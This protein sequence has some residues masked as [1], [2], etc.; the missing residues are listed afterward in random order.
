M[1]RVGG[2]PLSEFSIHRKPT[3]TDHTIY[4]TSNHLTQH[5]L[6]AYR[7]MIHRLH[8]IP[9]TTEKFHNEL[10]TIHGIVQNNG[11]TRKTIDK[12]ITQHKNKT[13]TYKNTGNTNK[14]WIT[15][16]YI[17]KETYRLKNFFTKHNISIQN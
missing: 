14:T 9:M 15:L 17:G 7:S 3:T 6:A 2:L 1:I 4:L 13:N 12:P 16:T 11:F 5:K 10:H 8:T